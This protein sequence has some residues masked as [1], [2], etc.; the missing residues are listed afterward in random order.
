M[1]NLNV[2]YSGYAVERINEDRYEKKSVIFDVRN[3]VSVQSSK[4]SNT[5]IDYAKL[6]TRCWTAEFSSMPWL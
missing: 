6:L 2:I 4:Y 5:V 1:K 3:I